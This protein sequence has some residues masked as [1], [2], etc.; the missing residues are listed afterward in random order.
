MTDKTRVLLAPGSQN[1]FDN[2]GR[3]GPIEWQKRDTVDRTLDAIDGLL[4]RYAEYADV[5]LLEALN[6][7]FVPGGVDKGGLTQYYSDV[8]GK[9]QVQNPDITLVLHDGFN[10]VDSWNKFITDGNVMMDNHHYQ[11]FDNGKLTK[12]VDAHIK[13]ICAHGAELQRSE[14]WTIVAEWSGARTDCAKYL[15]GKGLGSRYDGTKS[16]DF[17]VGDCAGKSV[18]TVAALPE[19]EKTN[20]RRYIESQLD[21]WE[22]N[23]GWVFWTWKTEGAPE[24]DMQQLLAEGVFPNPPTERQYPRQ[25]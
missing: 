8:W 10:P 19:G 6:E 22:E 11:V 25:C 14:K 21:A 9:L 2:S 17:K 1:G 24:W 15:N 3:R 7:P 18:G 12:N 16:A 23:N 5:V 20:I 13:D 4:D